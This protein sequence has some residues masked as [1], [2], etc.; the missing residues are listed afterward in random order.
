M[1][2]SITSFD[3]SLAVFAAARAAF[4]LAARLSGVVP[5]LRASNTLSAVSVGERWFVHFLS[6]RVCRYPSSPVLL[7][8]CLV[9]W[10]GVCARGC[11]H[12]TLNCHNSLKKIFFL[13]RKKVRPRCRSN[14]SKS[15]EFLAF[16]RSNSPPKT[17]QIRLPGNWFLLVFSDNSAEIKL[18]L[19]VVYPQGVK[20]FKTGVI[21]FFGIH[22][23]PNKTIETFPKSSRKS[24]Y[25]ANKNKNKNSAPIK[26]SA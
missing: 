25:L 2:L 9:C 12:Q 16:Y 5:R 24:D 11:T 23:R 22:T 3:S 8:A 10:S 26:R 18:T 6:S 17:I 14:S 15:V 7:H 19:L 4:S 20:L 13:K 21:F 1:I